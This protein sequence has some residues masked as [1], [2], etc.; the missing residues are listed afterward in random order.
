MTDPIPLIVEPG[1]DVT[2]EGAVPD[3]EDETPVDH[4][5]PLPDD[6]RDGTIDDEADA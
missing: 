1:A 5:E 2:P 3:D 4:G 6:V